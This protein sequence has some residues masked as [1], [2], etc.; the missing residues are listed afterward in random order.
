MHPKFY[1][2]GFSMELS[3]FDFFLEALV[4]LLVVVNPLF[5]L[6]TYLSLTGSAT[7]EERK[8]IGLKGCLFGF[9][10][11]VFFALWGKWF[12]EVVGI[13]LNAFRVSGG[14]LLFCS[15]Y[16]MVTSPPREEGPVK[17][18]GSKASKDVSIF[19]LGF[20]MIAG[21]GGISVLLVLMSEV[22][23]TLPFQLTVVS[24]IGLIMAAIFLVMMMGQSIMTFL[25]K[26]GESVMEKIFGLLIASIAVQMIFSGAVGAVT[27]FLK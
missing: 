1:F 7:E 11:L 22:P 25:G 24:V 20:P 23:N 8:K 19:P 21:P 18:K 9:F 27:E 15:G 3:A 2:D 26:S 10:L 14:I 17:E 13:S 4:K 5:V 12:L 6:P 16:S